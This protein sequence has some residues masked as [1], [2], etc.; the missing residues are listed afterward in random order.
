MHPF[1]EETPPDGT[2]EVNIYLSTGGTLRAE[3]RN[4]SEWWAGVDESP[5]DAPV[6]SSYVVGWDYLA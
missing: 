6:D 4:N 1:P 2:G 5:T 3:W